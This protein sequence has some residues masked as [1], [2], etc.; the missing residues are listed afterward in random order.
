MA[1][2]IVVTPS[3]V[4]DLE[5]Y[6]DYVASDSLEESRKW[7]RGAWDT[8]FSLREQP[9]RFAVIEESAEV[10][11]ELRDVLHHSHRIVYRVLEDQQ[12]VEVLRVWHGARQALS[13]GDL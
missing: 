12:V 1:Y 7:L 4:R 5:E 10:G 11:E 6:A 13:S 3:A 2:R 9:F 8:I